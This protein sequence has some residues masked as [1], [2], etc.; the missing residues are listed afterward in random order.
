MIRFRETGSYAGFTRFS[1]CRTE[2]RYPL[3]LTFPNIALSRN[4]ASETVPVLPG[5]AAASRRILAETGVTVRRRTVIP[6]KCGG[7]KKNG[8][9]S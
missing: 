3:F 8:P 7:L 6:P 4:V 9:V 2:N 1:Q 5:I